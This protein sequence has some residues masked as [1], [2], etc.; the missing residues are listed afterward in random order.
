MNYI[1]V[2]IEIKEEDKNKKIRII[3][4]FEQVKK[5]NN[6]D[7]EDDDYKYENEKDLKQYCQIKVRNR[8]IPFSYFYVFHQKGKFSIQ[9]IF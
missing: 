7:D 9:Y 6:W 1:N 2:E 8:K 5:Q 3:N 4:S